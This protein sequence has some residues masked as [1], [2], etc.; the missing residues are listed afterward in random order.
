MAKPPLPEASMAEENR[1]AAKERL[2]RMAWL[3]DNSI[4][5]PGTDFRV[6]LDGLIGLIPGIGDLVGAALSSYILAEAARLG[7]PKAM[8]LRMGLNIVV[9]TIIG[10]VPFVG[11]VFDFAWKANQRNVRLLNT[12]IDEP[13]RTAT[14][15]RVLVYGLGAVLI[16]F[17]VAMVVLSA[18]FLRW[19]FHAIAD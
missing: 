14:T 3:L 7:V 2:G 4:P 1:R 12:Y 11:D 9:E 16:L 19:L 17:I 5:L 13:R 18:I 6:G 8:L 10:V 15:S